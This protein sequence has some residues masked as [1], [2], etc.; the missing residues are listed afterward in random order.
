MLGRIERVADDGA[1]PRPVDRSSEEAAALVGRH[2]VDEVS[3]SE[4][5]V[6]PAVGAEKLRV[7]AVDCGMKANMV[8]EMNARGVT[9]LAVPWDY[10]FEAVLGDYDGLFISNG[11]GDPEDCRQ[12]IAHLQKTLARE[13]E[14]VRPVFGIARS[15][16]SI[17]VS[18]LNLAMV[19]PVMTSA[20]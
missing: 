19:S 5:K 15:A 9:L 6:F 3:L 8:R 13:G 7:I 18:A 10:D 1:P 2:L 4:P 20:M 14:D 16:S 12:T 17:G 11:P